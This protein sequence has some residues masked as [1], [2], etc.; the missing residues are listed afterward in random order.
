MTD[1]Y[2][3]ENV[4]VSVQRMVDYYRTA[5][6]SITDF[7]EGSEIRNLLESIGLTTNNLQYLIS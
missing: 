7:N 5:Q 2:I 1:V 6:S 4:A 3:L